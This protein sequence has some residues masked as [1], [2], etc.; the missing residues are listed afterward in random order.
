LD[1]AY[2]LSCFLKLAE[3]PDISVDSVKLLLRTLRL[4]KSCDYS[5]EDICSMLAHASAYFVDTYALCGASMDAS[6]VGNV[7][8]LL[9][10]IGHCYVQDE[11]CKLHVWHKYLFCKYC[12]LHTL[13]EAVARLLEI[14]KYLL[15]IED[16]SLATRFSRL[17]HCCS[18]AERLRS[19]KG[20]A[21]ACTSPGGSPSWRPPLAPAAARAGREGRPERK[22]SITELRGP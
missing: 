20:P 1:D 14:R 13:N 6:E 11:T 2:L 9:I 10:F 15:R 8:A 12:S 22:S 4:L 5:S 19:S 18:R 17:L 21:S 16:E 7:L 3:V